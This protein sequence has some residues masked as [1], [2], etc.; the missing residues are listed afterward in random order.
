MSKRFG[1]SK[2]CLAHEMVQFKQGE[3][4]K[5]NAHFLHEEGRESLACMEELRGHGVAQSEAK[6]KPLLALEDWLK[7]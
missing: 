5:K 1:W 2:A 4:R 3:S 7:R 6:G